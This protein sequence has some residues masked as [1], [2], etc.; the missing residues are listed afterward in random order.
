[1]SSGTIRIVCYCGIV[2]KV[3]IGKGKGGAAYSFQCDKKGCRR[4]MDIHMQDDEVVSVSG[5]KEW[6][7]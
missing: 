2:W 3:P 6:W 7:R 5:A 1:M 4:H